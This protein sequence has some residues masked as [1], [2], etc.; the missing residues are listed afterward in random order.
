MK[1]LWAA[2]A[3]A[4][5]PISTLCCEGLPRSGI[6]T[7]GSSFVFLQEE[8]RDLTDSR[9]FSPFVGHFN[10]LYLPLCFPT[11]ASK[12]SSKGAVKACPDLAGLPESRPSC[13]SIWQTCA[14]HAERRRVTFN[15]EWL[16]IFHLMKMSKIS[17]WQPFRFARLGAKMV[18]GRPE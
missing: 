6:E 11:A 16:Q 10:V 1:S 18:R 13:A 9:H 2:F 3:T 15:L 14:R 4:A 5:I 8:H 7:L 17:H 12:N